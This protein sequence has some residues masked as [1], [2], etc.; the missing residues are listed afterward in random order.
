MSG[1][2]LLRRVGLFALVLICSIFIIASV[3]SADEDTEEDEGSPSMLVD[4]NINQN[5]NG[6]WDNDINTT[7]IAMVANSYKVPEGHVSCC[8]SLNSTS[9][10][11]ISGMYWTMNNVDTESDIGNVEPLSVET[12]SLLIIPEPDTTEDKR[13]EE[14][15]DFQEDVKEDLLAAQEPDGSWNEDIGDTAIATYALEITEENEEDRRAKEKGIEWILEQENEEED[16]WGSVEDDSKA[17]LALDRAG[18]DVW[19]EIV[20]LMSKQNPDGS[21]GGIEDTAWV[22]MALSTH[23]NERTIDSMDRAMGWIKSQDYKNNREL[24]MAALAEQYYENAKLEE[25]RT[26]REGPVPPPYMYVISIL[27]IGSFILSYW[28]FARLDKNGILDGVRKDIYVY[29]TDHPGEHLANITKHFAIS[30]SSARYHLSV[31]EGMDKI[32]SHKNGKYKRFYINKN[33]YSKYTNGNGYKHIMSALKNGTARRIV[34]FLISNPEANQKSV[35]NA[36]SIHPSTVNW[37]AERLRDAEILN[38]H[39]KGKEIVYSLNED[40]QVKKVIGIIEGSI[41]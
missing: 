34:K 3:A 33:G 25:K 15:D 12:Q 38:K 13:L 28:L 41:V 14:I 37:H 30:S 31:L 4:L 39:K 6:S 5:T 24:A 32:V 36:L 40:V 9:T 16:S 11:A 7:A 27:V 21:F 17:I 23:P 1:E 10:V 26:E 8:F 35:S 19:E 18:I 20:A 29:I 22:V 2:Q